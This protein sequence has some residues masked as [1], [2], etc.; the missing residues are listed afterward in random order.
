[1][2]ELLCAYSTG[3]EPSI[4]EKMKAEADRAVND[5]YEL[6]KSARDENQRLQNE[7]SKER[8]E[9]GDVMRALKKSLEGQSVS[10][11]ID[12]LEWVLEQNCSKFNFP[13]SKK[14]PLASKKG[15]CRKEEIM[16]YLDAIADSF[17]E[18]ETSG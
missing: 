15:R 7:L 11:L 18:V 9:K 13:C 6:Y 2:S 10:D 16:S 12:A 4:P 8:S 5:L 14:C 1:M 3:G 17:S